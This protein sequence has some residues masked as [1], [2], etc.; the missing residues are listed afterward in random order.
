[1]Q[2]NVIEH[3]C[4][5]AV[6]YISG[7]PLHRENRENGLKNPCQGKFCQN[8]GNLGCSS[9]KFPESKGKTYFEICCENHQFFFFSLIKLPSQ[10]CVCNSHKS[11]ELKICLRTGKK[12]GKH[13]E[14]EN[15]I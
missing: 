4:F 9:C 7:Y 2:C 13:R 14:F 5:H 15:A 10:F 8:I 11:R 12:Q 6:L 1:M 3:G